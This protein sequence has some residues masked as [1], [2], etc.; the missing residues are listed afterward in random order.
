MKKTISIIGVLL[1]SLLSLSIF[2]SIQPTK[3]APTDL[4]DIAV[5]KEYKQWGGYNPAYTFSKPTSSVIRAMS[6]DDGFGDAYIYFH[7]DK[8]FLNGK[9]LRVSWH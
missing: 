1:I 6:T 7:M 8:D 4:Y 9:K 5:L 3:A 2:I